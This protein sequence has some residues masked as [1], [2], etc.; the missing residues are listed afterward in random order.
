MGISFDIEKYRRGSNPAGYKFQLY[1]STDGSNW[2]PAGSAFRVEF[3]PDADNTGFD[4]AP[5]AVENVDADLA[6][7][8][9]NGSDVYLQWVYSPQSGTTTTNSQGL[10]LDNVSILGLTGEVT[11][12]PPVLASAYAVAP[13]VVRVVLDAEPSEIAAADFALIDS[14]GAAAIA[15]LDTISG[16]TYDLNLTAALTDALAD[17][18]EYIPSE[19]TRSFIGG[20]SELTDVRS[21]TIAFD[22]VITVDVT[23][24]AVSG[25]NVAAQTTGAADAAGTGI[26]FFDSGL[27]GAVS[28]GDEIRVAGTTSGFT[29]GGS[30]RTQLANPLLISGDAGTVIEPTV[31]PAADFQADNPGGQNPAEQWE[32]VLIR[33]NDLEYVEAL[34]FNEHEFEGPGGELMMTVPTFYNHN[35]DLDGEVGEVFDI[36]GIGFE[37]FGFYKIA[38]RSADD[39]VGVEPTSVEYW[40]LMK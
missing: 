40:H 14:Q 9:P 37:S 26:L 5:G 7:T 1:H 35:D 25:N 30:T 33:V 3:G 4:P 19:S 17:T 29:S 27:A 24:T 34:S 39:I 11:A 16:T 18:V 15:T 32:G 13:D 6:L 8:I 20:I 21:G 22:E 2:S 36:I 12:P 10:G 38:P 31:V 28:I 23:V